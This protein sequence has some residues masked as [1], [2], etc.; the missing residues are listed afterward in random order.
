MAGTPI[1]PSSWRKATRSRPA[2]P[3]ALPEDSRPN[4]YSLAAARN[5]I[6]RANSLSDS[7][8]ICGSPAGYGMTACFMASESALILHLLRAILSRNG[9]TDDPPLRRE[10]RAAPQAR[11]AAE[12][13]HEQ[14]HRR[15]L[16]H[17]LGRLRRRNPL[18]GTGGPRLTGGG[19]GLTGSF[20]SRRLRAGGS[21]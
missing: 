5:R 17:R 10:T 7:F 16:D 3:A 8:N 18:P 11:R 2:S 12:D 19:A 9:P 4:S 14:A 21:P 20:G 13:Q 15:A 6:S 1:L